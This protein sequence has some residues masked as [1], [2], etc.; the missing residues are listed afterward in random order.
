MNIHIEELWFS[1]SPQ[2]K[3]SLSNFSDLLDE[4]LEEANLITD[5][6]SLSIGDNIEESIDVIIEEL[7][8]SDL[9]NKTIV[10]FKDALDRLWQAHSDLSYSSIYS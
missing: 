2:E 4:F 8:D 1:I 6:Y 3:K 5:F 9:D 7:E 10:K